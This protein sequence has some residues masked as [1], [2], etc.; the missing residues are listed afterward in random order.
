MSTKRFHNKSGLSTLS[1]LDSNRSKIDE[2]DREQ[3]A[4]LRSA[5]GLIQGSP[6]LLPAA[7]DGR[8]THR[9]RKVAYGYHIVAF[10]KFGYEQLS[11]VTTSKLRDDL[12]IS[13]LCGTRNCCHPDH[14][15]LES[16]ATNDERTHCHFGLKHAK[17]ARGTNGI[18]DWIKSSCCPHTPRCGQLQ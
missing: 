4:K 11:S 5:D 12:T 18:L 7:K 8:Y 14:L 15:I 9:Q 1:I 16:K 6:C 2:W 13:H 10:R 3:S 17:E